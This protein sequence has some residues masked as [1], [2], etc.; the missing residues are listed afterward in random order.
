ML[1]QIILSFLISICLPV[2]SQTNE[3]YELIAKGKSIRYA[4][5]YADKLRQHVEKTVTNNNQG[6]GKIEVTHLWMILNKKG[7]PSK[8]A[9]LMGWGDGLQTSVELTDG[10]YYL[11]FDL[12]FGA[13][14]GNR[15]G[16]LLKIP[17]TLKV[18]DVIEGG[19]LKSSNKFMGST[20]N[21]E[22]TFNNFKVVEE[23]D[24]QT[25]AGKIHCLKIVGNIT[26]RYQRSDVNETQTIYL[27]PGIGIV[28]QESD[29]YLGMNVSY[30]VE[31]SQINN[32]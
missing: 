9:K 3:P 13:S 7:K 2:F 21:N 26:G 27:A 15:S 4:C 20:I 10:S 24:L 19:T 14:M 17:K 25:G 12:C 5:Y 22:I 30:V 18:G 28:R 1:K 16:W 6:N 23:L 11:T 8:S 32:N 31:V 29:N